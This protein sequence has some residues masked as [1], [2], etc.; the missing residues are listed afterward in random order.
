MFFSKL[1]SQRDLRQKEIDMF[2]DFIENPYHSWI[3]Q[4]RSLLRSFQILFDAIN[5]SELQNFSKRRPF[6]FLPASGQ[7]SCTFTSSVQVDIIIVFPDLVKLLKSASPTHAVSILAHELGHIYFQHNQREISTLKAQFEA[8]MFS[9]IL[10]FGPDLID[11]LSEF[12][13]DQDCIKRID[14]I[15]KVLN[16]PPLTF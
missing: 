10:G 4:D 8:D 15:K 13:N 5:D 14:N 6:I 3:V 9:C 7:F 16:V 12:P 11:I 1:F 2:Q